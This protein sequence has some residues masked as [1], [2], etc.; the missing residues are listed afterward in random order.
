M[1]KRGKGLEA[2]LQRGRPLAGHVARGAAASD[3]AEA[4]TSQLVTIDNN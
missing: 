2:Q 3:S 1:L 4:V